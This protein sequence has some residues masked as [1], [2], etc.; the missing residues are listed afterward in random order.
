MNGSS[1]LMLALSM[2][3]LG[4]LVSTHTWSEAMNPGLAGTGGI[5][6]AELLFLLFTRGSRRRAPQP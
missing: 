4:V 5:L 2:F 6:L 1:S 3:W